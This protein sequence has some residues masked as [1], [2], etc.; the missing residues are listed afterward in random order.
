MR[1]WSSPALPFREMKA[2]FRVCAAVGVAI[3]GFSAAAKLVT[4]AGEEN[5]L[6]TEHPFFNFMTQRQFFV[7]FGV[8]E[9]IAICLILRARTQADVCF[10]LGTI[11]VG[12]ISY[13][14]ATL[15]G[16]VTATCS[17]L[18]YVL[19]WIGIPFGRVQLLSNWLFAVFLTVTA[20]A[21]LAHFVG[22]RAGNTAALSARSTDGPEQARWG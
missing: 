1:L 9:V 17:C 11:S 7:S 14:L 3:L 6:G 13:R 22:I 15:V 10:W 20:G 4:S 19:G 8:M 16:R 2:L 5:V 12:F 21:F 18:G